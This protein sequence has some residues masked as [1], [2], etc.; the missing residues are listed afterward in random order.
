M[1]QMI[2]TM[3][4]LMV[5][6]Y[7]EGESLVKF[8]GTS[9]EHRDDVIKAVVYGLVE[10]GENEKAAVIADQYFAEV[11]LMEKSFEDLKHWDRA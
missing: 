2:D 5:R 10:K 9:K 8:A 1:T 3:A 6:A 4:G 11:E 7:Y